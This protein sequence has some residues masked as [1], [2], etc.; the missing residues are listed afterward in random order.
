MSAVP[1]NYDTMSVRV[2]CYR[3]HIEVLSG[4]ELH[5]WEKYQSKLVGV[6]VDGGEDSRCRKKRGGWVVRFKENHCFARVQTMK[7]D[8]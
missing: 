6:L 7:C 8:L 1:A 4:V 2:S 3:F 5:A